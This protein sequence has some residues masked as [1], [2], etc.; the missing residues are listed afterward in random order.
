MCA[1]GVRQPLDVA[2]AVS[3]QVKLARISFSAV[4]LG[5]APSVDLT[6]SVKQTF[7]SPALLNASASMP[8]MSTPPVP[9]IF[10]V[11]VVGVVA[12]FKLLMI[13]VLGTV[14]ISLLR[15]PIE[16]ST[17]ANTYAGQSPH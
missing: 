14:L 16:I 3:D 17:S 8:G 6:I 7:S 9:A 5:S 12:A 10:N 15:S 2:A 4:R 11:F 1:L 13:V